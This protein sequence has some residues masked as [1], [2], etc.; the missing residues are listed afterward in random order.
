VLAMLLITVDHCT[1]RIEA[2]TEKIEIL[3]GPLVVDGDPAH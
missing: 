3:A 2:F 1:T